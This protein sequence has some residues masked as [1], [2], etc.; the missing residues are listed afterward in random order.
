MC[1]SQQL[2]PKLTKIV[3]N[4]LIRQQTKVTLKCQ[5]VASAAHQ[6]E[7]SLRPE[8][9]QYWKLYMNIKQNLAILELIE[10][11][12]LWQNRTQDCHCK[13]I[14]RYYTVTA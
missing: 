4:M 9:D 2:D 12:S 6:F 11:G 1:T 3:G 10:I 13:R 5:K 14:L 7:K 8:T